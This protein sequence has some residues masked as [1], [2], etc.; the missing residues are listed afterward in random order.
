M[1]DR[2]KVV[3]GG[4]TFST[5]PAFLEGCQTWACQI[6]GKSYALGRESVGGVDLFSASWCSQSDGHAQ[7]IA[8]GADSGVVIAALE[9][10]I[11]GHAQ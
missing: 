8:F 6:G 3:I 5:M 7:W 2:T 9:K 4:H 11:Q 1:V 10:T